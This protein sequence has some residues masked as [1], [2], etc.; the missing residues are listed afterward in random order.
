MPSL[1]EIVNFCNRRIAVDEIKDFQGAHN[2]LQ[3]E[4][5]GSVTKIGAAVD[6]GLVPFEKAT[7]ENI[8]FV[9]VHHG[10]FWTPYPSY[11]SK[12]SKDKKLH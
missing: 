6:A 11:R 2:G 7:D 9:I 1:S 10:L 5:N 8:D 3:I 4:N 12:L